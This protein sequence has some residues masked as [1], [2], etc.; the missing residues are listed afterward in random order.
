MQATCATSWKTWP[1]ALFSLVADGSP[2]ART[3]IRAR[4]WTQALDTIRAR[5][6]T[7]CW[8]TYPAEW[9]QPLGFRLH[10]QSRHGGRRQGVCSRRLASAPVACDHQ[11]HFFVDQTERRCNRCGVIESRQKRPCIGGNSVLVS[12]ALRWRLRR[13]DP[14]RPHRRLAQ[15]VRLVGAARRQAQAGPGRPCSQ[16]GCSTPVMDGGRRGALWKWRERT[17]CYRRAPQLTPLPLLAMGGMMRKADAQPAPRS[18]KPGRWPTG[19]FPLRRPFPVRRP[20]WHACLI[21]PG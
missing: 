18:G 10:R 13:S 14:Q 8:N 11:F 3:D 21:A 20:D 2:R 19:G 12:T 4:L 5:E 17:D 9:E 1:N 16:L 15:T 6:L 7:T